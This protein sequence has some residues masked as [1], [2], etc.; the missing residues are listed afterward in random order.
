MS[1]KYSI[2]IKCGKYKGSGY[3][4]YLQLRPKYK[5]QC[6]KISFNDFNQK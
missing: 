6:F 4:G 1:K 2:S 5:T 3:K